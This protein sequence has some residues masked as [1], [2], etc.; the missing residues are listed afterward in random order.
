MEKLIFFKNLN[1]PHFDNIKKVAD[2]TVVSRRRGQWEIGSK[3]TRTPPEKGVIRWHV[4]LRYPFPTLNSLESVHLAN[5]KNKQRK[6]LQDAGISVPQTWFTKEDV[7]GY[8]VLCRPQRHSRGRNFILAN[9][10]KELKKVKSTSSW[11]FS[12]WITKEDEWRV[13]VGGDKVLTAFQKPI[14]GHLRG[15]VRETG[16]WGDL[17][18]P[19]KEICELAI[20]GTGILGLDFAGVDVISD[21]DNHYI[22]EANSSPMFLSVEL[23]EIFKNYFTTWNG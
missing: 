16:W 11:Y 20:Q 23:A 12:Q 3:T 6:I 7:K 2:V 4:E 1:Q 22:S 15:N 10:E 21:K 8:P 19:P 18:M 14:K 5:S 9:N 13:Y 17:K